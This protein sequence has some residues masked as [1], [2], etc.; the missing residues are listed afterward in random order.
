MK[1][2]GVKNRKNDQKQKNNLWRI[3][4]NEKSFMRHKFFCRG[5]TKPSEEAGKSGGLKPQNKEFTP[6]TPAPPQGVAITALQIYEA[7]V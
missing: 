3:E 1:L 2:N 7:A 6:V 5:A 4:Q